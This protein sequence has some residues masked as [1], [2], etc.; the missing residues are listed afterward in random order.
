MGAKNKNLEQANRS[1]G[2]D[3]LSK[4]SPLAARQNAPFGAR[5][6]FSNSR[7]KTISQRRFE[8]LRRFSRLTKHHSAKKAAQI[9]GSSLPTLWRWKKR[10]ATHGQAGLQPRNFK[11]GRRSPFATIKLTAKAQ[12]ELELLLV[13]QSSPR[14]AW[15]HFAQSSP[16]CPPAVAEYVQRYGR[17]PALLAAVGRLRPVQANVMTSGDDRRLYVKLPGK[18]TLTSKLAVPA[19]FSL[20]KLATRGNGQT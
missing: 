6:S 18:G 14:L 10:L 12:R 16:N 4:C 9:V 20:V 11:A 13:E 7:R 8:T 2:D 3:G 15:Q 19:G 5:P 1:R 17:A